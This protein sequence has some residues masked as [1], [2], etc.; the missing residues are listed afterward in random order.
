MCFRN[1]GN[2]SVTLSEDTDAKECNKF[3]ST[4][5]KAYKA[6]HLEYLLSEVYLLTIRLF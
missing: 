3:Y 6:F 4:K 5:E 1:D 2:I